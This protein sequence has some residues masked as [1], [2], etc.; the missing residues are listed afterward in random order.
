VTKIIALMTCHNRS[1][2][3]AR[4]LGSL[5]RQDT[6]ADIQVVLVDD[7]S[8]DDT[9]TVVREAWP[10]ARI[11]SGDGTLFWAG[12]MAT[13]E[14]E[15]GHADFLL[16]LNDDVILEPDA[17]RRLLDT[18]ASVGSEHPHIVV[19]A[20]RDALTGALTYSGV[21]R[22]RKN[23]AQ[24]QLVTPGRHPR[25]VA[26][27]NGNAVLVSKSASELTGP[28]DGAFGHGMADFDYGLRAASAGCGVWLAP[29]TL[30]TC[31]R[32]PISG[33]WADDTLPVVRR[34]R[35]AVSRKGLPPR[36]WARFTRKHAGPLWPLYWASPYVRLVVNGA[37]ARVARVGQPR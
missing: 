36:G 26:T 6:D 21:E 33:T 10:G 37:L 3:T 22:S 17:V 11:I 25:Q 35:L 18:H 13:A 4:C 1:G 31:A 24:F 23:R 15:A 8:T 20:M 29:G 2:T 7:G 34:F 12:G 19:G 32:N 30:G 14:R 9:T 28:I 16:W 5:A 27:M